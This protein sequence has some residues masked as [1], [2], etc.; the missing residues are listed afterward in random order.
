MK[1][2]LLRGLASAAA[3]L[4]V[5]VP[6]TAQP[7]RAD[8]GGSYYEFIKV[9]GGLLDS[10]SDGDGITPA[11][12]REFAQQIIAAMAGVKDDLLA[13]IDSHVSAEMRS[14]A[15]TAITSVHY[16]NNPALAGQYTLYV[17]DAAHK[18]AEHLEEVS[19][20]ASLDAVGR[21]AVTLWST[22]E[23][24]ESRMGVLNR[25]RMVEYRGVLER[26][27]AKIEVHC[28]ETMSPDATILY[29]CEFNDVTRSGRERIRNGQWENSADGGPWN[30]GR[31]D[32]TD[33]YTFVKSSTAEKLAEDALADLTRRGY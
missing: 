28:G 18:A 12:F 3:A 17:N 11:E 9:L 27:I 7:A 16:L 26:V 5:A 1:V 31:L 19:G 6:V 22:L 4:A 32:R 21:A 29:Q 15:R 24:A 30:P 2:T 23:V 13:R 8:E 20:D 33:I 14:K 25:E 10:G